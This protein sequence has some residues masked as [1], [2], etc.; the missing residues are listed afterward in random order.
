MILTQVSIEE[1]FKEESTSPPKKKS[2]F[3]LLKCSIDFAG[4]ACNL[5]GG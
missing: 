1:K 2:K 3:R 5:M 4:V